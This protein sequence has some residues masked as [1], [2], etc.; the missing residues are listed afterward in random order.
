M[1]I[2]LFVAACAAQRHHRRHHAVNSWYSTALNPDKLMNRAERELFE[3]QTKERVKRILSEVL[4]EHGLTE[5]LIKRFHEVEKF[6][7]EIADMEGEVKRLEKRLFEEQR[8]AKD[9]KRR[10]EKLEMESEKKKAPS[11]K[12]A[13]KKK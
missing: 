13:P 11:G 6:E 10:K 3:A 12:Q 2:L 5:K 9:A 7:Q 1:C 4:S 8:L